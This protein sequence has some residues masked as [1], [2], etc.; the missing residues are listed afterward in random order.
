MADSLNDHLSVSL[1][2]SCNCSGVSN[3]AGHLRAEFSELKNQNSIIPVILLFGC[4]QPSAQSIRLS[5][6]RQFPIPYLAST[7]GIS[8]SFMALL[9]RAAAKTP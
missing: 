7:Q 8:A 3:S 2:A 6:Y 4:Y 1:F 9:N 5:R